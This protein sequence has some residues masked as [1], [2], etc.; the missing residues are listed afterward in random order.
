[1]KVLVTGGAGF[2]GSHIVDQ[3]LARG[4]E[5]I[6]VDNLITG[7]E[8]QV[9]SKGKFYRINITDEALIDLVQEEKPEAIIHQAAQV[10]VPSSVENPFFDAETNVIGTINLLE[11]ARRGG[12]RKIVY[13][14]SA[15]VYGEPQY[16]PI[17][18]MHPTE[19][20]SP[21]GVSKLT[22][23]Q[24][25]KMY[26]KEHGFSYSLL[27]Y[28]NIYGVRQDPRGE[29]GVISILVD[30]VLGQQAFTVFGDGKQTR[31]YVY[32]TDAAKANVLALDT[33]QNGTYNIGTGKRTSLLDLI[34]T[35]EQVTERKM[36][37][38]YGPERPGDIVHSYYEIGKVSEELK[39]TPT[40]TLVEG[41]KATIKYYQKSYT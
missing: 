7:K 19:P 33:E 5:V 13:A 27:R 30:K 20:L 18:E 8:E 21:Y 6:I 15:A 22:A 40:I 24:Y 10:H 1:M 23:E 32:V 35:F 3:L 16:L 37:V 28:A 17:N 14:S 25:I 4:D 2:I 39:W 31:D 38:E 41:L 26:A 34:Q 12:V 11:A 36:E 29:G 9:H